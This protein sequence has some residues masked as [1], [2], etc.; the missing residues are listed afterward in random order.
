VKKNIFNGKHGGVKLVT[1]DETLFGLQD[2][3]LIDYGTEGRENLRLAWE[4]ICKTAASQGVRTGI[5]LHDTT[6]SLFWEVKSLN[7]IES[8][9]EDFIYQAEGT[10]Q[11]LELTDKFLKA[12]ISISDFD[13]L[14]RHKLEA[15]Q[16]QKKDELTINEGVAQSWREIRSGKLNPTIFLEDVDLMKARLTRTIN[17]VGEN[18]VPYAGP[19]CGFKG[20]PSY[21]CAIEAL[22]RVVDAVNQT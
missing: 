7:I 1:V 3:S 17:Q 15:T 22:R 16:P 4:S 10:K 5:H 14:I 2:D 20:F 21:A 9:V 13:K 18:R 11:K 19:E 12:S 6:D 8:H